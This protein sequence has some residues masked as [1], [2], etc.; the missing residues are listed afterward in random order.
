MAK[1]KI[2]TVSETLVEGLSARLV[3]RTITNMWLLMIS[4]L[5]QRSSFWETSAPLSFQDDSVLI[6]W[7]TSLSFPGVLSTHVLYYTKISSYVAKTPV[8]IRDTILLGPHTSTS[9][10]LPICVVFVSGSVIY[11]GP[12]DMNPAACPHSFFLFMS[13]LSSVC[14]EETSSFLCSFSACKPPCLLHSP[15]YSWLD[16]NHCSTWVFHADLVSTRFS[17]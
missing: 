14:Q 2:S 9:Q 12:L 6:T 11:W 10:G 1:L 13:P 8:W 4:C 17:E 16:Q 7:D 15:V 3:S 5:L